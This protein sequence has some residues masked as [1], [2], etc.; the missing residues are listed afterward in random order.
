M[1]EQHPISDFSQEDLS[2]LSQ[3]GISLEEATRQL[4]LLKR[5]CASLDIISAASLEQ[6]I[7]R[8]SQE[9]MGQYLEGWHDYLMHGERKI[10]K[11]VPASGAATRMFQL[12]Y[13]IEEGKPLTDNQKRF[14]DHIEE[15]A[16]WEEL[17][18]ACLRN[19]WRTI[20]KLAETE[21][22]KTIANNLLEKQGLNY[23]NSPKGMLFF[24]RYHEQRSRTPIGEHM[25]EGAMYTKDQEGK[26]RIHFTVSP[27][28]WDHFKAVVDRCIP[29]FQDKYGV[30][31]DVSLSV[32]KD[33]TRTLALG[34]DHRPFREKEDHLLLRP[35]G[36]GALISNLNEIDAE[37]VFIKNIDNVLPDH[38]KSS[39]VM[40]KKLLGGILLHV[41]ERIFGYLRQ[42]KKGKTSEGLLNEILD[43]M[44]EIL[45]IR[46]QNRE[47][48]QENELIEYIRGKLNRP[49]R[50]CGM[51]L[52]EGEPGGGPYLIRE[53][54]GSTSLQILESS[55]IGN[56]KEDQEK[57][58]QGK[59]FN[60]VDLCCSLVDF[61]GKPFDL[62][63]FVNEQTSFISTKS[64]SGK[65]ATILERPGLWN[66]AM[67]HWN[68]LFVEV[69]LETFS[70]VKTVLDLLKPEHQ[71]K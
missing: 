28:H 47:V 57:M 5:G 31:Y 41:R 36:H 64:I 67:H 14:F 68:T 34:E 6:G 42:L 8:I 56:N 35:G 49:I 10:V 40:Y 58:L 32:Q 18:A 7:F 63:Q 60:P 11:F 46:H 20:S 22:Y 9:Q 54:D 62:Y 15:F 66:G 30:V 50:V 13:E 38:L 51:V 2:L 26:V 70:P 39:T 44:E 29:Y 24:H 55:Q 33:D 21:Q 25:A 53:T 3:S 65:R 52:N 19:D 61:E 27:E 4:N 12:L 59:Y 16:F 45:C 1:E 23:G 17:N 43:F 48:L 71:G 69:P 37:I